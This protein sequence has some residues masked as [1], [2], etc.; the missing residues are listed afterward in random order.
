MLMRFG[1]GIIR[2]EAV[3]SVLQGSN[4]SKNSPCLFILMQCFLCYYLFVRR[5]GK[6]SGSQSRETFVSVSSVHGFCRIFTQ[7]SEET[8]SKSFCA[9]CF[10]RL[11]V[12][13]MRSP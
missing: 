12:S 4:I 5:K 3:K 10:V 6:R 1:T 9:V 8:E 7:S 11:E 13:L 2:Q